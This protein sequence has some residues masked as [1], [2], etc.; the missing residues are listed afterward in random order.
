MCTIMTICSGFWESFIG[1]HFRFYVPWETYIS[2]NQQI[3]A[4]EISLLN[5]LSY[6]IIV[7]TVVSI[8]LYVSLEIIRLIQSKWIDWDNKMYYEPNN[9]QAQARTTTLNE[10][11]E[12]IQYVFADKTGTLTQII[13]ELKILSS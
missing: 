9:V 13:K 7:H 8:S 11:L 1:Y 10:E 2:T 4:L 12:Q 3:C 5:F 6:V